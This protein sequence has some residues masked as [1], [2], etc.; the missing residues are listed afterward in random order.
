MTQ[1]HFLEEAFPYPIVINLWE[2]Y[3]SDYSPS[4]RIISKQLDIKLGPFTLNE[5]DSELRKF[6]IEKPQKYWRP[7]NSTIFCPNTIMQFIIKIWLTD[8]WWDASSLSL[9]KGD[10]GLA[11]NYGS[12]TFTSIGAKIYNALLRNRMEP[13][14][15]NILWKNQNGFRR[16]R[17]TTSQKLTI[18]N[19]L[20]GVL[21]K[22]CWR[23]YYLSTLPRPLIPF[24][25]GRWN[26]FYKH[27]AY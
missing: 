6:K 3:E 13:K 11:K 14:I 1:V 9:K 17:S 16:N 8:G 10:V 22:T 19:I 24:T 20:E 12:I 7:D 5:L 15:Y 23:Q 4:T 27:T 18:C 2:K 21:A 26:K 25:E